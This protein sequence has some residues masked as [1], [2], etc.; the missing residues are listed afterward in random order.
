MDDGLFEGLAVV[1]ALGVALGEEVLP[2]QISAEK[3]SPGAVLLHTKSPMLPN[4]LG[5]YER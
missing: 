4:R 3:S 2:V 1:E 5:S